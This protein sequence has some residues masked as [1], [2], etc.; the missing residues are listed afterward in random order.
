MTIETL[1]EAR[2]IILIMTSVHPWNDPRIFY[3]EALSLSKRYQVEVHAP[4]DFKLREENEVKVF[5]LPRYQK[6]YLRFLNWIRLLFRALI[7]P[8]RYI[9]FHDPELI[10]VA[11]VLKLLTSKKVI[12]D[13]HENLPASIMTK[14]WIPKFMRK[15]L[16]WILDIGERKASRFFDG[17]ILAEF[18]YLERFHSLPTLI[19]SVVNYPPKAMGEK[20]ERQ[21]E[22]SGE[23]SCISAE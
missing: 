8:A 18:S 6:R 11:I 23:F 16:A 7:S 21:R 20:M 4:A 13:V 19:Q 3:K 1:V 12:Y 17:I 14:P 10:P 9:H 15:S 5:G 2:Q 22:F